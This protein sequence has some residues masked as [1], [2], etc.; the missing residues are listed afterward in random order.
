MPTDQSIECHW[1]F[2]LAEMD[3]KEMPWIARTRSVLSKFGIDIRGVETVRFAKSVS[4][5]GAIQAVTMG[6]SVLTSILLARLLGTEGLGFY[7]AAFALLT[8]V[9]VLT[10][11][12]VPNGLVRLLP[13]YLALGK[14]KLARGCITWA[15]MHV[16]I[17][18]FMFGGLVAVVILQGGWIDRRSEATYLVALAMLPVLGIIAVQRGILQGFERTIPSQVPDAL[19]RPGAFALILFAWFMVGNNRTNSPALAMAVQL[20]VLILAVIAGAVLIRRFT[21]H[22]SWKA[23]GQYE[24]KRWYGLC[25]SLT[26]GGLATVTMAQ[27]A[28]VILPMFVELT[29]VGLFRVALSISALMALPLGV[30][31]VPLPPAIAR[32]HATGQKTELQKLV[33]TSARMSFMACLAIAVIVVVAGETVLRLLYGAEFVPAYPILIILIVGQLLNVAVG[34]AGFIL[35]MTGYELDNS[36]GLVIAAVCQVLFTF[37]LAPV[38]GTIGVA[39]ATTAGIII[40]NLILLYAVIQRT[41]IDPTPIGVGSTKQ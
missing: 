9:L 20:A 38:Y 26:T 3:V 17:A 8:I 36:R 40:Q 34:S 10:N 18:S 37:A 31:N 6:L 23:A 27:C 15:Y 2:P 12:S 21:P 39:V 41:G 14:L 24:L 1:K 22:F 19:V 7:S 29:D 16:T 5:S 13:D 4:A 32:L 33:T 35:V 11:M 25:V 30:V 28:L